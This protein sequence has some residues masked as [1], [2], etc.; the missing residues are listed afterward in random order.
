MARSDREEEQE[1]AL[2]ARA[3]AALAGAARHIASLDLPLPRPPLQLADLRQIRRLELVGG[4]DSEIDLSPLA[5]VREVVMSRFRLVH[6]L[7]ALQ[8]GDG[9]L[10][11]LDVEVQAVR[12]RD[13]VQALLARVSRTDETTKLATLV[14]RGDAPIPVPLDT[15]THLRRL[16]LCGVHVGDVR[17][18][19]VIPELCL[20][21]TP[22]EGDLAPLRNVSQGRAARKTEKGCTAPRRGSGPHAASSAPCADPML[23]LFPPCTFAAAC[24]GAAARAG[25]ADDARLFRARQQR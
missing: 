16:H 8:E 5:N 10:A 11:L 24:A 20:E 7:S 22:L 23:F 25:G 4:G 9:R 18:L 12:E 2:D 19:D 1:A 15:L 3:C 17:P 14:L 6:G 13:L 21:R